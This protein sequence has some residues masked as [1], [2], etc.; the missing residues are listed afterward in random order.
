LTLLAV[1]GRRHLLLAAGRVVDPF[2][3]PY[4]AP[5]HFSMERSV[6]LLPKDF[7]LPVHNL[8]SPLLPRIFRKVFL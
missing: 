5:G 6:E 3:P 7:G 2:E 8:D 4:R 1:G